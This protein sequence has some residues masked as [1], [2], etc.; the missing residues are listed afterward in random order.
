MH[1]QINYDIDECVKNYFKSV[2]TYTPLKKKDERALIEDY[3]LNGNI[4][5]RDKLIKANL[6]YA[7]SIANTY[8]GRGVDYAE[9]ISEAN[10]GLIESIDKYDLSKN[11]KLITYA[12]WWIVWHLNTCIANKYKHIAD[13]LPTDHQEQ[14]DDEHISDMNEIVNNK[15]YE[16]YVADEIDSDKKNE[17]RKHLVSNLLDCLSE[18]ERDIIEMYFGINCN[19]INLEEIGE[20]YGITRERTRQIIEAA[21]KKVRSK[22]ILIDEPIYF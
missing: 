4:S 19:Q 13:E 7:S 10:A 15:N 9:L 8:R 11:V 1:K 16:A 21:F 22:A 20:V 3:L 14:I 12:K 5:S 2:Q 18:R 6:K 17:D